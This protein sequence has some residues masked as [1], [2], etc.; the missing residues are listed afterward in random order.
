MFR[1]PYCLN[2][3]VGRMYPH[4]FLFFFFP[5]TSDSLTSM[6][7]I[8]GS[9]LMFPSTEG[10]D[11]QRCLWI[12][13][14]RKQC[15]PELYQISSRPRILKYPRESDGMTIAKMK[16]LCDGFDGLLHLSGET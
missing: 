16:A 12:D 11:G 7:D 15:F 2:F 3:Q 4:T 1:F 5:N 6:D 10:R 14:K 8:S 13:S 9:N